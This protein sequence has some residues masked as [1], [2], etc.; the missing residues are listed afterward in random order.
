MLRTRWTPSPCGRLSRPPRPVVA[1]AT[2]TSPP[3]H[4]GGISRRRAFPPTSIMLAGEGA[5]GMVP[6]FTLAPLVGLGA[7]LCPC[8]LATSYAAGFHSWPPGRRRSTGP[9]VLRAKARMRAAAQP[10]SAR[11]E[12]VDS[13]EGR[14]TAGFSRTPSRLACRTRTIWQCWPVPSLSG[15]LA[16]LP[17][18]PDGVRLPPASRDPLRR[19]AGGVLSPPHGSRAP[20]GAPRPRSRSGSF[21]TEISGNAGFGGR[22]RT[23]LAR[24]HDPVL[25]RDPQQRRGRDEHRGGVAAAVRELAMRAVDRDPT[26]RSD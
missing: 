12:L 14:S 10:R 23:A 21:P 25:Q 15:L 9:G 8:S 22:G 20:R 16:T 6:T 4:P 3:S 26:S 11:F 13:L 24:Q 19:A 17:V 18:R 1:P 5:A 7:Q 2:T